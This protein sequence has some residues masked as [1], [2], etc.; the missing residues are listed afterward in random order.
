M[1]PYASPRLPKEC[2]QSPVSAHHGLVETE[3][4]PRPL[5]GGP[6]MPA[7]P[8]PNTNLRTGPAFAVPRVKVGA[9]VESKKRFAPLPEQ[10]HWPAPGRACLRVEPS[11]PR[12]QHCVMREGHAPA[13]L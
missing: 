12:L 4:R 2:Q 6:D 9:V 1:P 13:K 3:Q 7:P 5:S 11:A 10:P 8:A